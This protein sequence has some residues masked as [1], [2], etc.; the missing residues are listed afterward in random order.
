MTDKAL[1]N[2]RGWTRF[3]AALG[4]SIAARHWAT[5]RGQE[6]CMQGKAGEGCCHGLNCVPLEP[7]AETLAPQ[8]T[9]CDCP[10]SWAFKKAIKLQ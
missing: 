6:P 7:H 1:L 3:L 2:S 5:T 9:E 4:L 10:W 8:D